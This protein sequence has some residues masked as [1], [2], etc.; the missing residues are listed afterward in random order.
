MRLAVEPEALDH[1]RAHLTGLMAVS[2]GVLVEDKGCALAVHYR[3]AL[4]LES[5]VAAAVHVIAADLRPM[6]HVQPGK[7]VLEIEPA[8]CSKGAAIEA[9]MSEEPFAGRLPVFVGDDE[10][11][12][13]GFAVVNARR[14]LSIRVGYGGATA[15]RWRFTDVN[16]VIRWL[17]APQHAHGKRISA[18]G[19]I[20]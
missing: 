8:G 20:S 10:T 4:H 12:E 2:P 14:G 15:A 1:A 9:Y 7:C 11:D 19:E 16:E 18:A 13:D 6:F 3:Q 17:G 5:E